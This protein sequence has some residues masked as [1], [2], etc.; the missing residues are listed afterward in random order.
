[1]G[2][3]QT[4]AASDKVVV[5]GHKAACRRNRNCFARFLVVDLV[6]VLGVICCLLALPALLT[7]WE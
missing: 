7:L 1:M 3:D 6:T 2:A 4:R 5:Q